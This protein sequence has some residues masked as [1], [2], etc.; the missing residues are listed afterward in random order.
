MP[1]ATDAPARTA[2]MSR[3]ERLPW[4][5]IVL[6]VLGIT[7]VAIVAIG[8]FRTITN[9]AYSGARWRDFVILGIAQ[10]SIYALI[11]LGYTLVYGI[12][13][14]INFAHGEVFMAGAFG[15]YFFA[16][17]YAESGFLERHPLPAIGIVLLVAIATSVGVALL[18]E[19][20]AYRPLRGAP[21]LVPLITAIG[22]SLFLQ[23]T[24]RALFGPGTK[25]FPKPEIVVGTYTIL[26]VE[27][28]RLQVVVFLVAATAVVLLSLFVARTTTGK[29]MRAVAEDSEI[30]SLMG[31]DV[32]RVIVV[33]FAI[34]GILA[35]IAGVLFAMTFS[36]VN[37]FMGVI[38]GIA[39]F[40]AAV[41][42]GIGSISGAAIG[43]LVL[44]LL[45]SLG[46]AFVLTGYEI[47]SPFQLKNAFTFLV[48]VLVLIFRPGGIL[49]TGDAEKV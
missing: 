43:G 37:F 15:S 5:K 25:G 6:V 23:N 28:G 36:G 27:F 47:P 42:G 24:A 41:L 11:A 40:T 14:M 10:G 49:G 19:R 16:D 1:P 18:L 26:G 33:T 8:G 17:A 31:I 35:G 48:L 21:R 39:A 46:P 7:I 2:G 13:R 3:F 12:L 20:V 32:D 9:D 34:G 29:S 44:G 4:R 30:A 22:A 45:E 38:P